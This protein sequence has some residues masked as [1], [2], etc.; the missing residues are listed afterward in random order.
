MRISKGTSWNR[1]KHPL[2]WEKVCSLPRDVNIHWY[3]LLGSGGPSMEEEPGY[4]MPFLWVDVPNTCRTTLSSRLESRTLHNDQNGWERHTI[5]ETVLWRTVIFLG[6]FCWFNGVPK[7]LIF[8]MDRIIASRFSRKWFFIQHNPAFGQYSQMISNSW[9]IIP[10]SF[11]FWTARVLDS[12]QA[13]LFPWALPPCWRRSKQ[14]GD[15]K[16]CGKWIE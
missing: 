10:N 6:L 4:I 2:N 14:A 13:M 9:P 7:P 5:P 8:L 15:G 16:F 11:I 12:S 1:G 3:V